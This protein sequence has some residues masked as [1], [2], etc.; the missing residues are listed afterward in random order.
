MPLGHTKLY[1]WFDGHGMVHVARIK[2]GAA[3]YSSHWLRTPRYEAERVLGRD[4]F[5]TVVRHCSYVTPV[6][7]MSHPA[8]PSCRTRHCL[9]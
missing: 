2:G 8:L 5:Q 3:N 4:Y 6:L 7:P 9:Y 1:H